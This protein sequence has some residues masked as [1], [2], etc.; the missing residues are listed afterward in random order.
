MGAVANI[1]NTVALHKMGSMFNSLGSSLFS[2]S[3]K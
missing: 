2:G 3:W 1:A